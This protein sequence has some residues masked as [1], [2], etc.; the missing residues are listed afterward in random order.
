MRRVV[1]SDR[2]DA[3]IE[4]CGAY[5]AADNLEA[6][7]AFAERIH[8]TAARLAQFPE[9]GRERPELGPGLRSFPAGNYLIFYR[10]QADHIIVAR[11]LHGMR[12]IGEDVFQ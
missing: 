2:A 8:E 10:M 7:L 5:I 12:D 3:D 1:F 9:A 11:V 4:E 6:G